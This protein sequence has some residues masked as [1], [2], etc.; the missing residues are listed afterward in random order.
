MSQTFQ[1]PRWRSADGL[2]LFARDYCAAA[3]PSRLPVICI[4]GLTLNSADFDELA[5]WI[6]ARGRRV[7]AVDLRGRGRSERDLDRKHYQVATYAADVLALMRDRAIPRA[8][9]SAPRS[10]SWSP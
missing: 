9:L 8:S 6:C 3:N 5:T 10:A 4:P 7:L 1:D 2:T